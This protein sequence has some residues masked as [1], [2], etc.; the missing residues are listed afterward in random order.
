LSAAVLDAEPPA[1]T[2]EPTSEQN[3]R[4]DG[5]SVNKRHLLAVQNTELNS[6]IYSILNTASH[7]ISTGKVHVA[8]DLDDNLIP[9]ARRC[10]RKALRGFHPVIPPLGVRAKSR[11]L[12]WPRPFE[13]VRSEQ[14]AS[15]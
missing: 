3:E 4:L 11:H 2:R 8:T 10:Q 7:L 13:N 14:L 9:T 15:E 6:L 5:F 1:N 12:F